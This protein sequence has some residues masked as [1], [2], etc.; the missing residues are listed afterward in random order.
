MSKN[1][2]LLS[3]GANAEKSSRWSMPIFALIAS[4]LIL[5]FGA[6]NYFGLKQAISTALWVEQT[7]EVIA[8]AHHIE[9]RIIDLETGQRGYLLTGRDLFL[10]PYNNARAALRDQ[11]LI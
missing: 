1:S 3:R 10:E 4:A 11:F 5:G 7:H 8:E 6:F 2:E 9:R